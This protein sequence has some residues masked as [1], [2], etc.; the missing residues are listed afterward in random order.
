MTYEALQT[1]AQN[2]ANQSGKAT[3]I[4]EDYRGYAVVF[5]TNRVFFSSAVQEIFEPAPL[6][7]VR[8]TRMQRTLDSAKGMRSAY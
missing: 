8:W 3:C 2:K 5:L 4:R 6:P 7:V 1:K